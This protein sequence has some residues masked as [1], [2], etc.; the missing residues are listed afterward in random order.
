M[1]GRYTIPMTITSTAFQKG[2]HI[3]KEQG[4]AGGNVSPPLTFSE[5]PPEAK[6]LVL[7]VEDLDAPHGTFTHWLI[8]NM[9]PATMQILAGGTP[10]EGTQATNDFGNQAYDGPAPPS[11]AHRYVFK[12]S[13]LDSPLSGVRPTDTRQQIDQ[14]MEGHV[15]DEAQLEGLYA[16]DQESS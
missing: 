16:A 11:G 2:E 1:L 12:L 9:S 4:H 5:V 8:Y 14:A 6:S 7:T 13:A 3:P 15:I 10:L